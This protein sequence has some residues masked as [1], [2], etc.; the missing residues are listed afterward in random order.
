LFYLLWGY[1]KCDVIEMQQSIVSA[2]NLLLFGKY[3][4][5]NLDKKYTKVNVNIANMHPRKNV[6]LLLY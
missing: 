6:T 1:V 3:A 4:E 2:Y 5:L